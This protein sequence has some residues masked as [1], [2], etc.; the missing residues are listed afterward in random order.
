MHLAV[1][2]RWETLPDL[3]SA[4]SYGDTTPLGHRLRQY[5]PNGVFGDTANSTVWARLNRKIL[6]HGLPHATGIT[7]HIEGNVA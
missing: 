2:S 1:G 5:V 7:G 3:G 6:R 4:G